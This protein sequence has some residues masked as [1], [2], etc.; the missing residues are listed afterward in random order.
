ML[1]AYPFVLI[2]RDTHNDS[3]RSLQKEDP[4]IKKKLGNYR[5]GTL[6]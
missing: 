3:L 1:I 6:N 2:E 5:E 4:Q